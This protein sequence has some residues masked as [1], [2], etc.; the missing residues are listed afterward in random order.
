VIEQVQISYHEYLMWPYTWFC[1]W[2]FG[3]L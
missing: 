1:R 3:D 2:T